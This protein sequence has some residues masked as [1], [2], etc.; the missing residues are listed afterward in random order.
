MNVNGLARDVF[1]RLRAD[2]TVTIEEHW[3][4][5]GVE[6]GGLDAD[7]AGAGVEHSVDAA[8]EIGQYVRGC[9]GADV[10]EAVGGGRGKW[11]AHG[12]DEGAGDRVRRHA[13]ADEF[14]ARG[15][16]AGELLCAWEKQGERAGPEGVDEL[17][18]GAADGC[19]D[20]MKHGDAGDVDDE[21]VP[22]GTVFCGEDGLDGGGAECVGGQAVDSLSG[23]GDEAAC[24]QDV[25][26]LR[27]AVGRGLECEGAAGL[28]HNSMVALRLAAPLITRP[29]P[30]A[31]VSCAVAL[32]HF[33]RT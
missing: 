8:V 19:D 27:D 10:A 11:A 1:D 4:R 29:D 25:G 5:V 9:G 2:A 12:G 23:H 20:F 18:R 6:H 16:G 26:G 17:L 14:P 3:H 24:A 33:A 32:L 13:D 31:R 7:G 22:M 28:R 30:G 15:D 21:R